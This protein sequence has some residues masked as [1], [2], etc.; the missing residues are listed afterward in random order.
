MAIRDESIELRMAAEDE[1]EKVIDF[2]Y[3]V[4]DHKDERE[5]R[6]KW[7][8]DVYPSRQDLTDSVKQEEM[9]IGLIEGK[10][11]CAFRLTGN[12]EEYNDIDWPTE[13]DPGEV[14]VI[15]LLAV[16]PD[17]I[18]RGFAR[19]MVSYAADLSRTEGC[20]VIR[21]DVLKGNK[22]AEKLYIKCG[23]NF[24]AERKMF[25]EDTGLVDFRMFEMVL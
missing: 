2:Y 14:R 20:K 19:M 5:F 9:H 3:Y 21:L 22:P 23:F 24:I 18:R 1:T 17:F 7:E 11:V 15:H 12:V 8:K 4:I 25:Y 13:A 10:I 6:V 16:H